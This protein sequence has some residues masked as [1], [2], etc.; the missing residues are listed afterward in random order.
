MGCEH[1][2]G[3]PFTS[4]VSCVPLGGSLLSLP[5]PL[6]LLN[7]TSR[8]CKRTR[9]QRW[10]EHPGHHTRWSVRG[11]KPHH[12]SPPPPCSATLLPRT[13]Y[14]KPPSSSVL[15][16][17][18]PRQERGDGLEAAV[19][20][21][22][23]FLGTWFHLSFLPHHWLLKK[24][25][26]EAVSSC[27]KLLTLASTWSDAAPWC[28]KPCHNPAVPITGPRGKL[29]LLGNTKTSAEQV[30]VWYWPE[31]RVNDEGVCEGPVV[32][33]EDG[34]ALDLGLFNSVTSMER[35]E[36]GSCLNLGLGEKTPEGLG[37]N[38]HPAP[39]LNP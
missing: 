9:T 23:A 4:Q 6:L 26:C 22:G 31:K 18:W 1:L 24:S 3:F 21:R 25:V 15:T 39:W 36:W 30:R 33:E 14:K 2:K 5:L 10:R 16:I 35:W 27:S 17:P 8:Y 37:A 7:C 20:W 34:S 29:V 13:L 32:V 19:C 28:H 38:N 12:N 11:N